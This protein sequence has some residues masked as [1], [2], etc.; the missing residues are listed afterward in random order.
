MTE[1][2]ISSHGP[3]IGITLAMMKWT[4]NQHPRVDNMN[5]IAWAVISRLKPRFQSIIRPFILGCPCLSF[6]VSFGNMMDITNVMAKPRDK[7]SS[8]SN[9]HKS[10]K[11]I[12]QSPIT[13][14]STT[15]VDPITH[16]R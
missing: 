9:I 8:D 6:S 16:E 3:I 7:D 5:T 1:P 11:T 4:T 13:L 12:G 15:N 2:T 10:S 14:H